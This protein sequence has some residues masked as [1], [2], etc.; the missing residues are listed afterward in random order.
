[1]I[2]SALRDRFRTMV[3]SV[4][5]LALAACVERIGGPDEVRSTE[6][7]A[8]AEAQPTA[9][10]APSTSA[11]QYKESTYGL[12][13]GVEAYGP[14]AFSTNP[15]DHTVQINDTP[16]ST[17]ASFNIEYFYA[18]PTANGLGEYY[19]AAS[20]LKPGQHVRRGDRVTLVLKD[21]DG[22]V[23]G[24]HTMRCVKPKNEYWAAECH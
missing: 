10:F 1:M 8:S 9:T 15:D 14:R 20:M 17:F 16:P 2:G 5:T 4:C 21:V 3:L 12:R 22:N 19:L 24:T 23:A 11:I 13:V 18:P 7:L 6:G